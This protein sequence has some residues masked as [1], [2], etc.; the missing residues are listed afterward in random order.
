MLQ[1]IASNAST[2]FKVYVVKSYEKSL[3]FLRQYIMKIIFN[4]IIMFNIYWY[5]YIYWTSIIYS[6][7]FIVVVILSVNTKIY[8]ES[9]VK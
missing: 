7:M 8:Y 1:I 2:H 9:V 3:K 6:L 5:M 4:F